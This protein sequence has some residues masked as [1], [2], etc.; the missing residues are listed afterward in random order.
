MKRLFLA[1]LALGI[2]SHAWAG[3]F[4][5]Q[6]NAWGDYSCMPTTMGVIY[7]NTPQID[8]GGVATTAILGALMQA[9]Q[10]RAYQGQ[11]QEQQRQSASDAYLWTRLS[12]EKLIEQQAYNQQ[13]ANAPVTVQKPI[14]KAKARV[15]RSKITVRRPAD[16]MGGS[17]AGN[18]CVRKPYLPGC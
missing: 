14:K 1:V 9:A 12:T 15:S 4:S 2:T 7:H 5:C 6:R 17:D 13:Y 3:G 10:E 18:Q 16:R 8:P 11:V